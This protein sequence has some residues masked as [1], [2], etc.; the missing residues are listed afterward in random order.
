MGSPLDSLQYFIS[1]LTNILALM[2]DDYIFHT[3]FRFADKVQKVRLPPY[4]II[5]LGRF[6]DAA[7]LMKWELW[8]KICVDDI[9]NENFLL[10]LFALWMLLDAVFYNILLFYFG[11]TLKNI[12]NFIYIIYSSI[13]LFLRL[14]A[15]GQN[16][17]QTT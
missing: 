2:L 3:A 6:Y 7:V 12:Y 10:C 11:D 9:I 17:S 8:K 15:I 14:K 5:W 13:S 4:S 16:D 1:Q